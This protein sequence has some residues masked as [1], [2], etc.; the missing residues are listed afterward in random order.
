MCNLRWFILFEVD[1]RSCHSLVT[2]N[3]KYF[4]LYRY[5]RF[6]DLCW[7]VYSDRFPVLK[8]LLGIDRY[9]LVSRK[10]SKTQSSP[11]RWSQGGKIVGFN[12]SRICRLVLRDA[13]QYLVEDSTYRKCIFYI[14]STF[15]CIESH[16]VVFA[17]CTAMHEP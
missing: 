4:R 3:E 5:Q 17:T 9:H 7:K 6:E 16:R 13:T 12:F 8:I 11:V 10:T 2:N 15:D 1:Y 14:Y